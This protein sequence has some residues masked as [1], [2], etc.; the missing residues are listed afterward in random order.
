MS[1]RID[2]DL[3]EAMKAFAAEH[4]DRLLQDANTLFSQPR[5]QPTS[6]T[7]MKDLTFRMTAET[8]MAQCLYTFAKLKSGF[9]HPKGENQR[10]E[11]EE[12][13]LALEEARQHLGK[14]IRLIKK[15]GPVEIDVVGD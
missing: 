9:V 6:K 4:W 1:E 13:E 11:K 7:Y 10:I 3:T 12:M 5:P 8:R 15:R 2:A 14:D